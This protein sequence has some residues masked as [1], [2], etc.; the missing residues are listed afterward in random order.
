LQEALRQRECLERVGLSGS[1]PYGRNCGNEARARQL[2][3]A[4]AFD[5]V[6]KLQLIKD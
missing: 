2:A 6:R 3:D 4:G 1:L 5:T